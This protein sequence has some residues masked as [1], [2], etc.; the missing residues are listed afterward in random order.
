MLPKKAVLRNPLQ[1]NMALPTRD[2]YL[3]EVRKDFVIYKNANLNSAEIVKKH[4]NKRSLPTCHHC[5]IT[6]HIHPKCP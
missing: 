3:K 5:S 4:S 1:I 2:I 6:S